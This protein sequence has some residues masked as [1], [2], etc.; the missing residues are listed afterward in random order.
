MT[1]LLYVHTV[2]TDF[3]VYILYIQMDVIARGKGEKI[4]WIRKVTTLIQGTFF[5]F[6][7]V[8]F[9]PGSALYRALWVSD[10]QL[11]SDF[12]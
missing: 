5:V 6:L 2:Y 12:P 10:A 3:Q 9:Y 4:L 11:D 1:N 7:L 8:L